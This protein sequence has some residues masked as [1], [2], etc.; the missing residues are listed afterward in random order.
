M[1]AVDLSAL[2]ASVVN[3]LVKGRQARDV[4]TLQRAPE[5]QLRVARENNVQ[6]QSIDG[7]GQPTLNI[8][9]DAYHYWGQRLGYQCWNDKQFLREF[10][11]D[12]P[13]ARIKSTGTRIQSG[14]AGEARPVSSLRFRKSYG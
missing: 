12:N 2:P 10:K 5:H 9:S 6:H 3:E 7:I 4:L 13:A 8:A 14:S 11:R 1:L